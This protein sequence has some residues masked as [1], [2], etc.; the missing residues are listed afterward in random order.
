M[1]KALITGLAGQDGSYLA[2]LLLAK[3]YEV[4]GTAR[5]AQMSTFFNLSRLGIRERVMCHS[6]ALNDFRMQEVI[7]ALYG[8]RGEVAIDTTIKYQDGRSARIHTTL[9]VRE[10]GPG[11]AA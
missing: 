10:L 2:E 1:K 8:G 4:H 6:M 9:L 11:K 7:A 5:D 3:G